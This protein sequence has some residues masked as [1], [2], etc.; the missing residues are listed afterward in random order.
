MVFNKEGM[1]EE[2]S[3]GLDLAVVFSSLH[4]RVM[5]WSL[6]RKAWMKKVSQ[7]WI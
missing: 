2:G 1:D 7:V 5:A 4:Q 6:T 3:S